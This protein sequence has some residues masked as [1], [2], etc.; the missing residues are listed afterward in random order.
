MLKSDYLSDL[1]TPLRRT[2][3]LT[4]STLVEPVSSVG[5]SEEGVVELGGFLSE[6][7]PLIS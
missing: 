4:G 6:K 7:S 2:M 5:F 1:L 3:T